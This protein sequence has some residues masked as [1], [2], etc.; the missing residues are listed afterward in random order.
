MP[1]PNRR[2]HSGGVPLNY[3]GAK[4]A[5]RFLKHGPS[6]GTTQYLAR[7]V[8]YAGRDVPGGNYANPKRR[9]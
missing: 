7:R 5:Y 4:K 9:K 8:W 6:L 1:V 2:I 3:R